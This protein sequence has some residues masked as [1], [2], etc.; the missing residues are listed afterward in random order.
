M[1]N[2]LVVDK[3]RDWA[4]Y[5]Q[6]KIEALNCVDNFSVETPKDGNMPKSG[7]PKKISVLFEQPEFFRC[8]S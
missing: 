6:K 7:S 4:L 2:R 1:K 8:Q 3:T 5:L